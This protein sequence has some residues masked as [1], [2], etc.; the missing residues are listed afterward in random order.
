MPLEFVV[1]GMVPL[2]VPP[3]VVEINPV[4]PEETENWTGAFGSMTE[5]PL[6]LL[7]TLTASG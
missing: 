6:V 2:P 7:E 4:P 3:L 1:E 5:D